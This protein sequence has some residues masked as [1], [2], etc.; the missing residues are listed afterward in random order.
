VRPTT[1]HGGQI[2]SDALAHP[3]AERGDKT[4]AEK[5]IAGSIRSEIAR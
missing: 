5:P 3:I 2:P 4:A 1:K